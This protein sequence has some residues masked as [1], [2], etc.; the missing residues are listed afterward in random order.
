MKGR[1]PHDAFER[2]F[3]LGDDRS[4]QLLAD[5]LGVSKQAITKRATLEGWQKRIDEIHA[6]AR[7]NN[8]AR[9]VETLEQI[10]ELRLKIWKMVEK[11]SLEAIR[12]HP[13]ETGTDAVRALDLAHKNMRLIAG[14]PTDR[15]ESIEHVIRGEYDRWFRKR[16]HG[17]PPSPDSKEPD[18]D[19]PAPP[20]GP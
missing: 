1:L 12:N 10:N 14:E 18:S 2:Y 20:P 3:A 13:F 6:K 7:A 17:S 15:T 5:Q 8:D 19:E 11:R 16:V 9:A 4:Y